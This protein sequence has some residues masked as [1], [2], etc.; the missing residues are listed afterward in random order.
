MDL[1]QR[2]EL[3]KRNTAEILTE[4]ELKKL[5]TQKNI[6]AYYGTAPTGPFHIGYF[7]PISKI[8]DFERAGIKSRIL[9]ADIHSALDDLK[10]EWG[11]IDKKTRYYKKCIELSFPWKNKPEFVSGSSFQLKKSYMLD[12]LKF[13]T[14]ST[15]TRAT[16]AASEVTRMKNPKVS[17][18]IYP[19]MQSLD[20][21]YLDVDIQLGG[22][23]QRHIFA[24]AREFLP[25]L[26]YKKRVEIMTPLVASL[27]G[28][29]TKMSASIPMSH[30]KVY[31]SESDLKKKIQKAYCPEGIL[32]DNPLLQIAKFLIFPVEEKMVIQRDSRFGGDKSYK[33]YTSL[34]KDFADKKLHPLDLKNSVAESLI[35]RFKKARRFFEK[36]EDILLEL[37]EEYL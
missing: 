29:G 4:A 8:F 34:E 35:K 10:S 20:E 11:D 22:I 19:I 1:K 17:E 37:G 15:T 26:G 24:Y 18:L 3:I 27:Q 16:R 21:Q 13:S 31:D 33:S 14:L 12:V 28:P 23:D 25:V 6:S 9:I 30:I 32:G 5:L 36:H 7:I 2:L